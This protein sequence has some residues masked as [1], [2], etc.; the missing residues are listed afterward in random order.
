MLSCPRCG[1]IV[2]DD[3]KTCNACGEPLNS[4]RP[5]SS[6]DFR[7]NR[8]KPDPTERDNFIY[9]LINDTNDTTDEYTPQDIEQNK[10][11][12]L[13][14][15]LAIL[16]LVPVFTA[17]KSRFARFHINQGLTL[18]VL[19]VVIAIVLNIIRF[20]LS[21]ITPILGALISIV[22]ALVQVVAIIYAVLGILNAV[23]GRAKELPF[24]GII[25]IINY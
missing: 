3:A 18:L 5:D 2:A 24:I 4:S 11:V 15:Y 22:L 10:T 13:F 17:P 23:N 1:A 8:Y 20:V 16:I 25:R 12:A 14:A 9:G 6:Q 7:Y 21:M 19:D